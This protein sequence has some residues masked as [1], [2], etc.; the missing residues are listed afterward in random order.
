MVYES[1]VG[2]VFTLGT[3]SWRIEDITR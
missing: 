3:T 1:R 2:D